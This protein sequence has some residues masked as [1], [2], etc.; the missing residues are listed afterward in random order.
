MDEARFAALIR[1]HLPFYLAL[2]DGRRIPSTPAQ[3]QFVA[4]ARGETP[5]RTEHERAFAL[6]RRRATRVTRALD[7]EAARASLIPDARR[8]APARLSLKP[9]PRPRKP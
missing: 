5:P 9:T 3:R 6:W 7:A 1:K 2:A 8:R 4:A